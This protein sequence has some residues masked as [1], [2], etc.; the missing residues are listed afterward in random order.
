MATRITQAHLNKFISP[1]AAMAPYNRAQES[2]ESALERDAKLAQLI[3]GKELEAQNEKAQYDAEKSDFE[4]QS[5]AN[6]NVQVRVGR[7]SRDARD[8]LADLIKGRELAKPTLTPGQEAADKD[9]GKEYSDFV[10]GGGNEA[11]K[12]NL[13]GLQTVQEKL[14]TA[15]EPGLIGR[16]AGYLPDS[17]RAAITP[18]AKAREDEVKSAIQNTL[19][20]TLGPQFTEKE[21]TAIL[22]RAYDPRLSNAEN[23]KRVQKEAESLKHMLEQKMRSAQQ[24]ENTGSLVGLGAAGGSTQP[25]QRQAPQDSGPEVKTINGVQ[26][27]RVQGGWKKAQ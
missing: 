14:K 4:A 8:R 7:F 1:E 10:A 2:K 18:E 17:F 12:K 5:A 19:R 16:A 3:R 20:Q 23:L 11:A 13:Q 24:F 22:N 6:P 15:P 25:M 26:Y 21:G 9:F 27:I